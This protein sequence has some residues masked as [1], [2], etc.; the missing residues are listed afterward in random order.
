M[1]RPPELLEADTPRPDLP[2]RP[3]VARWVITILVIVPFLWAGAGLE[4][5][6]ERLQ[7]APS[8][9]WNIVH[10]LVPPDLS[11]ETLQRALPKVMES[12]FIA[13]VGT[14]IAAV[15]SLPLAFLAARNVS[16]R[17]TNG[18][19]RQIFIAIRALP[20]VVIAVMLIPVTGLGPWTGTL[21]IGINSIGTLGKLSSEA[22]EGIDPGP[23]EAVKATGGS[24][25]SAM[26]FG[27]LPQVMP[28]IVAYWLYRFE[29]NIR[30]SAVLG[31]V[32]AGGIGLELVEQ[33]RFRNFGRVGTVLF[34]TIIVVLTIDT[35][36]AKLRR[37]ILSGQ[38]EPGPVATF[39]KAG[40]FQKVVT[41]A[42]A[43]V[44]VA[45]IAFLLVQLQA[46]A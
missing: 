21:A 22:I 33:I 18:A 29:I 3:R 12:L 35:I 28:T 38:R 13:W 4:V 27:V 37:R 20:E 34:L 41:I 7:R 23:V 42:F 40:G 31:I 16:A 43:V 44:A 10:R 9:I 26:R 25:V 39:Q 1:Y 17:I 14:M 30:A 2:M 6:W 32:G 45:F 5:S 24:K 11:P 19:I 36:S 46:E 8:D 15:L